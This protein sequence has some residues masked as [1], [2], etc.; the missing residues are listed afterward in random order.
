MFPPR[1]PVRELPASF[2]LLAVAD[3]HPRVA[4]LPCPTSKA[5]V[6]Y[7]DH[8]RKFFSQLEITYGSA[9]STLAFCSASSP[10]GSV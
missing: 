4:F 1:I 7:P 10:T 8:T 9:A 5:R 2:M 6:P 3:P